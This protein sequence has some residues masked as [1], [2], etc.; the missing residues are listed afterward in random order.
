M[1]ELIVSAEIEDYQIVFSSSGCAEFNKRVNDYLKLGYTLYGLPM[2][3][4]NNHSVHFS[5][6]VVKLKN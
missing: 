6:A 1:N 4:S 5:Q 3:T 2:T